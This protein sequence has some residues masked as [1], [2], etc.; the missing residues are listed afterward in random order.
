VAK[1]RVF[2]HVLAPFGGTP[3]C[4]DLLQLEAS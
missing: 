1:Q 4:D 3:A 2:G